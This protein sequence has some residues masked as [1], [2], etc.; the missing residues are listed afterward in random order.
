[1]CVCMYVCMYVCAYHNGS[2]PVVQSSQH[3]D[4][5][6]VLGQ[7]I[8]GFGRV[9]GAPFLDGDSLAPPTPPLPNA[10]EHVRLTAVTEFDVAFFDLIGRDTETVEVLAVHRPPEVA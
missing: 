5:V 8:H 9:A 4:L 7:V 1:M 3:L 10:F 6:L 2:L